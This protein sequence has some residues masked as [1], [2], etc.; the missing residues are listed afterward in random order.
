MPA[1][2]KLDRIEFLISKALIDLNISHNEFVLIH[3]A[4]KE[5]DDIKKETKNSND[6]QKFKPYIK[7]CHLIV[8]SAENIQNNTALNSD[9]LANIKYLKKY[10]YNLIMLL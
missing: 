7:Q 8:W 1:K 2:S 3:N 6:E 4:P 5:F 10:D 9:F